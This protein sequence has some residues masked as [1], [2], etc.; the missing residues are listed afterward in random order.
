MFYGQDPA[1]TNLSMVVNITVRMV[2]TVSRFTS[3]SQFHI[4]YKAGVGI[5]PPSLHNSWI[6]LVIWV[7]DIIRF[8]S[9][10]GVRTLKLLRS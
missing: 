2:M 7:E 10:L 5:D 4:C 1:L 3:Y 6:V 8:L 9:R